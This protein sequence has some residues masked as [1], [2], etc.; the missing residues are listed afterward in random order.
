MPANQPYYIEDLWFDLAREDE[1][2]L[3]VR[4]R[5]DAPE[6]VR[7]WHRKRFGGNVKLVDILFRV[8][9]RYERP[10]EWPKSEPYT[11]C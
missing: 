7:G 1:T 2:I 11:A 9:R 6:A 8:D 10:E 5:D 3:W 4:Y